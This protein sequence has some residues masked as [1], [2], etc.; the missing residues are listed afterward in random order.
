MAD[1]RKL[2]HELLISYES[3]K[4]Y[5]NLLLSSHR[6]AG[7]T[8]EE[9]A[10]LTALLY[11]TV[12]KKLKYDYIICSYAKRQTADIDPYVL[13]ALRL[14]LCQIYDMSSIPD[15]AAVNETV[16]LARH[17]GE[18]SFI[19]AILRRAVRE[20]SAPP[21]PDRE[22]NEARYLSVYYS[23][24]L[25]TVKYFRTLFGSD[26]EELLKAFSKSSPLSVTVNENKVS[27]EA[28]LQRLSAQGIK[29]SGSKYTDNGIVFEESLP[30][31]SIDGFDR[32]EFFVQ[33]EASRIAA[34]V[35]SAERG[36]LI[37]DV[38][39]APGGKA[40]A[41]AIKVGEGGKVYAFDLHASKLSLI[42]DSAERLGLSNIEVGELDATLGAPELLGK[43]DR[44]ICDVPCSGLGVFSKKPDLR[45]K[46]IDTTEDL[47][48][49]QYEILKKSAQY[50][51]TGGV[52]VYSTCTLDPK[53]NE[54]VT[55]KFISETDGFTYEDFDVCD[56]KCK[57]KIT[58]LPHV[59]GTDGFYIAKLRKL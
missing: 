47:P 35:L 8:K 42:K 24:P 5:V 51:K 20:K 25:K 39:S 43:A 21:L 37:V 18:S 34:R 7:L 46:D 27:K 22:K 54:L 33:D 23:V 52:L 14:G 12:E 31:K 3:E 15:F 13:A 30:P 6:L 57:G 41:A 38:C 59:H 11:T 44:V 32:G 56:L 17:K 53:E 48:A 10:M 40:L 58:L 28:L 1:V 2:T 19:N 55:D 16:K 49:L 45:Y 9:T 4:R 29:A 26:T 50:L 36:E